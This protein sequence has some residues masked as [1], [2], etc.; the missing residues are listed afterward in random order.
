MD[1]LRA[2]GRRIWGDYK[3]GGIVGLYHWVRCHI[4]NRYHILDLRTTGTGDMDWDYGWRDRDNVMFIACFKILKDFVEKEY[5]TIGLNEK[6]EDYFPANHQF[7]P[8]EREMIEEQIK[9]H[10]EVRTLFN[11]WVRDRKLEH[12]NVNVYFAQPDFDKSGKPDWT[13]YHKKREELEKRDDDM[14]ARL[15]AI[16]GCLWT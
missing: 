14:L 2:L 3:R 4:W 12:D 7:Y 11:W 1:H 13:N 8:G 10:N 6:V 5:P 9:W 16:R 15:I